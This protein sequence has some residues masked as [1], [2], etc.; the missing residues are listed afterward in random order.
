MQIHEL[1]R[2]TKNKKP[3]TIGRGGK[4]GKTSGKGHKGQNARSGNSKRPEIR[5]MIKR[6]PKLRGR[7]VNINKAFRQKAQTVSLT[8]LE[9]NFKDGERVSPSVLFAK[10]LVSKDGGKMPIVKILNSGEIT[11]KL[12]IKNCLTSKTAAEAIEK[13]GGKL[14]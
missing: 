3:T 2:K 7:G 4:R 5:D 9:N 14:K 12:E 11:K 8:D 13:A 1:K 6:I 10:G